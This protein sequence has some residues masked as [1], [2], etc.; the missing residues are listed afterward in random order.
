[1]SVD[2]KVKN[3][4]EVAHSPGFAGFGAIGQFFPSDIKRIINEIKQVLLK[5]EQRQDKKYE[6]IILTSFDKFIKEV[7]TE[8]KK[9]K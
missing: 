2:S 6:N 7:T 8:I 5:K 3:I 4:L 1:M 9:V